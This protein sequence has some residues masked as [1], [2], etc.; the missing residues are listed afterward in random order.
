MQLEGCGT[1]RLRPSPCPASS[2]AA[3]AGEA[4]AAATRLCDADQGSAAAWTWAQVAAVAVPSA[5]RRRV[6][7]LWPPAGCPPPSSVGGSRR[8]A[9]PPP[10]SAQT[11]DRRPQRCRHTAPR[12]YEWMGG[13]GPKA[14]RRK[15][16]RGAQSARWSQRRRATRRVLLGEAR[17]CREDGEAEVRAGSVLSAA[18]AAAVA[19]MAEQ[20]LDEGGDCV[21]Q[22]H[23]LR[24]QPHACLQAG[25]GE[26]QRV[27]ARRW[28]QLCLIAEGVER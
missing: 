24:L 8:A 26:A 21:H 5:G 15:G 3:D 2:A 18:E 22:Q 11:A 16:S 19:T 10:L 23:H 1:E 7:D 27:W 6:L 14:C 13:Q 12:V 25:S 28:S 20:R 9:P 4:A 17:C